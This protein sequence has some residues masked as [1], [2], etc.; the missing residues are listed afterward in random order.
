MSNSNIQHLDSLCIVHADFDI[1]SGQ[2][3]LTAED[4]KLRADIDLPPEKLALLGSKKICDPAR[5]KPFHRLKTRTRRLLEHY[6]LPFLNGVAV[7]VDK[8]DTILTQL[9]TIADEFEAE[10]V[11][12]LNTYD[13]AI[14]EWV[15]ENPGYEELIRS[16]VMP[17][18][19]V[20]ERIGFDYQSFNIAPVA[21]DATGSSQD[22]LGNRLGGLSEDLFQEIVKE[23]NTFYEE[24]LKA[25]SELIKSTRPTLNRLRDKVHGLCFLNQAFR[26]L[27][28][29]LDG[30]LRVYDNSAGKIVAPDLYQVTAA[31]LIMCDR[32]K[33]EGYADGS[34][35][36]DGLNG[37][38][39][40]AT[41]P[42]WSDAPLASDI[43]KAEATD[44]VPTPV[45]MSE[46]AQQESNDAPGATETPK[47]EPA[48]APVPSTPQV[49]STASLFADMDLL[50]QQIESA[51]SASS[52]QPSSSNVDVTSAPAEKA[53]ATAEVE[54]ETSAAAPEPYRAEEPVSTDDGSDMIPYEP[55]EVMDVVDAP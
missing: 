42:V 15:K 36:V 2:T 19:V 55:V 29:L 12:F 34:V 11:A 8:L 40:K 32:N 21:S 31:V 24:R 43:E 44:P 17:R 28:G 9:D 18:E 13:H 54:L 38:A 5:M 6:G 35:T 30:V 16:G 14:E 1:W 45:P 47:E 53:S 20:K 46:E 37:E 23:A 52:G 3:R 22:R 39:L 50:L 41:A 27:V 49:N 25:K 26:P 4:L 7:P 33:I 10:R 48:K 51:N